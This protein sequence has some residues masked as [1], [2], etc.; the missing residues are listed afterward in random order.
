MPDFFVDRIINLESDVDTFF[1]MLAQAVKHNGGS[2]DGIGQAELRGGN[3]VNTASALAA[4]NVRVTPIICTSALGLELVKLYLN[5]KLVNLSNTK[6]VSRTS[7][8]TALEFTSKRERTN[9]MLRDVGDL[10]DFGPHFL[11]EE[12]FQ[13]LG[14][15]DYVCVFNWAGTKRFGTHLAETVF[16]YVKESGKGKTY[17]D[18]ADPTPKKKE[19]Q[20]LIR[21]VFLSK[22]VDILSLNENEAICFASQMNEDKLESIQFSDRESLA[23]ESARRLAAKMS[24]RIDLHTTSCSATITSKN[25]TVVPAFQVS[26]LRATGA[27]DAWNSGNILG[28]ALGLTDELRLALANAVAGYYVSDPMGAHPSLEQLIGFCKKLGRQVDSPYRIA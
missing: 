20:T 13:V 16:R 24:T 23:L 8:T 12:D 4:L 28:D 5:S 11:D 18:T 25:E 17:Y 15:A 27:G 21:K 6:I 7:L 2:I 9:V 14:E 3:A 26:L 10:A 19:A 1:E 22:Y